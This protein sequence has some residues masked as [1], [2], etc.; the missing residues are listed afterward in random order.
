MPGKLQF[1]TLQQK[2]L[3]YTGALREDLLIGGGIGEDAALIKVP[4]GILVA[5]S[6]PV[7]GAAKNAGSLLVHI[8]ANDVACKGADP[9]W[10]IVTLIV[11]DKLGA[12][13]IEEIMQEIHETCAKMNIAIAGGHTEFTNKYDEP[14]ISG[15]MLGLTR[16]ELNTTKICDG[17]FILATGHVGLEGMSIIADDREDLFTGI[18]TTEERKI[19]RSWKNNLSVIEAAKILREYSRYMH[20]PTEGG[21]NGALSEIQ[22]AC[23]LRLELNDKNIPISSLTLRASIKL[24]FNPRNLISSG[25]LIAVIPPDKVLQAQAKLKAN[26]INSNVI[27]KF[28]KGK[29]I[30][31]SS[32]EE[33][34][35]ILSR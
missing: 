16:Y 20:D 7:T 13:F 18:F 25:M 9:A 28:V 26:N 29:K 22:E 15:T 12:K 6:D 27:G 30:S 1:N 10:L 17:D 21:L 8:N 32:Y 24:N 23:N 2:V 11:P 19:I 5:A 31:L 34:W 35:E 33:L 14:V 4:D 3:N